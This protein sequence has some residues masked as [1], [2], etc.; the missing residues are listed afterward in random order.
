MFVLDGLSF[1]FKEPNGPDSNQTYLRE[2]S[3]TNSSIL[4]CS[5]SVQDAIRSG[6]VLTLYLK[7]YQHSTWDYFHT[8]TFDLTLG[9]T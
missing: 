6:L 7:G 1:N 2:E 5:S 8:C 4:A 3:Q 9:G